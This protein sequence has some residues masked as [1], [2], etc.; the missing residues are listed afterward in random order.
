[1]KTAI[2]HTQIII[3]NGQ[4]IEEGS[5]LFDESGILDIGDKSHFFWRYSYRWKRKNGPSRFYRFSCSPLFPSL[6]LD[7]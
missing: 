4:L 3:G 7:R 6:S 1:M 2:N 5:I